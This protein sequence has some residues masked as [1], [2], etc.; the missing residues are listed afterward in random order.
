ML[1]RSFEEISTLLGQNKIS[2]SSIVDAYLTIIQDKNPHLNAFT[3][4]FEEEARGKALLV[5]QKL[6]NG[7]A[8]RLAGMVIG[9]KDLFCYANHELNCSSKILNGFESQITATVVQRLVD[10]DA[11]V[12][13]RQNCDEFGMGSS[14]ENSAKGPVKNDSDPVR[15]PGGSSGGSAVAVQAGMCLLSLASDTG[16]SIRQPAAFTGTYGLK[17]TYGRL[18]RYGLTAYA[19]SFD[20]PGFIGNNTDD[21]ALAME[22]AS[23]YDPNDSTS[24]DEPPFVTVENT[25]ESRS[26]AVFP[27]LTSES[28]MDAPVYDNYQ[29]TKDQLNQMADVY[30][31][32]FPFFDYLLPIYYI[33]TSAEASANLSRFDGVRYGYRSPNPASIEE[34]YKKTRTEGFGKEVLRRI[35]LGTFVLSANYHDAFYVKALKARALVKKHLKSLFE[36]YDFILLPTTPTVAFPLEEKT[37]DPVEMYLSDIFTTMASIGGFP[38]ISIPTGESPEGLPVGM[39]L[40]ANEFE[41]GNLLSFSNQLKV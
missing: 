29:L 35:L 19:S 17:P 4:V 28:T 11:I 15:V 14:N 32:E 24:S 18:S 39:Q 37:S 36:K 21:I 3:E 2:V 23:G 1:P 22:V 27:A 10:E 40:I 8:G 38:A 16:G 34:L 13:G 41:E 12:I 26:I 31:E 5:D 20:C 30:E 7:T 25:I 9:I 6:A 33:L